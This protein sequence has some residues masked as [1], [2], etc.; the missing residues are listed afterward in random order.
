MKSRKLDKVWIGLLIGLFGEAI[1]FIFVYFMYRVYNNHVH[2]SFEYFWNARFVGNPDS[3][4]A[5][6]SLAMVFNAFIF[7]YLLNLNHVRA[8][9]GVIALGFLLAPYIVYLKF[10]A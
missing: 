10:Y 3:Q 8:A 5:I 1:G 7:F 4:S 6:L 9:K 2:Y